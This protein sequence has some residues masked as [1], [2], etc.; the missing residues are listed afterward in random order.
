MAQAAHGGLDPHQMTPRAL[1]D[2]LASL[3]D[4]R[5]PPAYPRAGAIQFAIY[6]GA[7]PLGVTPP[8]VD[9]IF[10]GGS[11]VRSPVRSWASVPPPVLA[12]ADLVLKAAGRGE[13]PLP[14]WKGDAGSIVIHTVRSGNRAFIQWNASRSLSA[15][16]GA[17]ATPD[18]PSCR[19]LEAAEKASDVLAAAHELAAWILSPELPRPG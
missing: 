8:R 4:E 11:S 12:A 19:E 16:D 18:S 17:W 10:S 13:D 6:F 14:P 5:V 1:F 9:V 7:H 2:S 3:F 15:P